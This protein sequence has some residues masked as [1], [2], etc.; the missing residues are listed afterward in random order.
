MVRQ[1][2]CRPFRHAIVRACVLIVALI[3]SPVVQAEDDKIQALI[4]EYAQQNGFGAIFLQSPSLPYFSPALDIT[5]NVI[6]IYDE[7]YP[8]AGAEQPATPAA[9]PATTPSP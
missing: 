5:A 9:A 2:N 3:T 1:L 6:K 8:V 7:K 4:A